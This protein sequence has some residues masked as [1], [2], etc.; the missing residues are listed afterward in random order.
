MVKNFSL[1]AAVAV[2]FLSQSVIATSL[3][4]SAPVSPSPLTVEVIAQIVTVPS[5]LTLPVM[6][7]RPSVA[8]DH[9]KPVAGLV[10]VG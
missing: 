6:L 4:G 3:F 2:V 10:P 1:V 9:G 7:R 8:G 5:P